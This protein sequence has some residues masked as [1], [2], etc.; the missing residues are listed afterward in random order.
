MI[1]KIAPKGKG[2]RGLA[3]YLLRGGRGHIVGGPMA[4]QTPRELAHEFGALRKLNPRLGKAVAHLMLSPSEDDPPLSDS[5]WQAIA[6]RYTE[7]MGYGA[8]PWVAVVHQDTD[9]QHLHIIACRINFAGKTVSD[10]NDFRRS[11]AIVRKLEQEFGLRRLPRPTTPK[12][13]PRVEVDPKETAEKPIDHQPGEP[14]MNIT[15]ATLQTLSSSATCADPLT[16]RQRRELRRSL[17]ESDYAERMRVL[18]GD[19][20]TRAHGTSGRATLYFKQPGTIVDQGDKLVAM[21]GM[22]ER[23]A[24]ER[25]VLLGVDRG[26]NT[27]AFTGSASFVERAMR[28]A[29]RHRLTVVPKDPA[30]EAILARVQNER[31]GF[32]GGHATLAPEGPERAHVDD[33]I[34]SILDELDAVAP[35]NADALPSFEPSDADAP[36]SPKP[37]DTTPLASAS[38]GAVRSSNR[39][40]FA[41][42][43]R[44]WVPWI[45][46]SR[47]R[48]PC[49]TS[50][51]N[52][53][54]VNLSRPYQSSIGR[55]SRESGARWRNR[56]QRNSSRES[57]AMNWPRSTR[58][59]LVRL[60]CSRPHPLRS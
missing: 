28:E 6:T 4:G 42:S 20:F 38:L 33:A 52:R 41:A 21:G 1:G 57:V 54:A 17:V 58:T 15:A 51:L 12:H 18:L 10:S 8:S 27:I 25:I 46:A 59:L 29:L 39:C 5:Q 23:L 11:E 32:A 2:F 31:G 50:A 35:P 13:H 56:A 7:A 34:V 37:A 30:Q 55:P 45:I 60:Y 3:A 22:D 16:D 19:D 44:L 48:T 49:P 53:A 26:W 40:E 47:S 9:H 14:A 43:S 36:S 24:A